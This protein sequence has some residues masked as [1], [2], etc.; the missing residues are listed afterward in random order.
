[1]TTE[2]HDCPNPRLSESHG[3]HGHDCWQCGGE[4][5][6]PEECHECALEATAEELVIAKRDRYEL[7]K[8]LTRACDLLSAAGF[9]PT[10]VSNWRHLV[11][12]TD[13]DRAIALAS[14]PQGPG[15]GNG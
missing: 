10:Q 3:D 7:R 11:T 6:N 14:Q 9:A 1:V 12:R 8:A 15:D 2:A 13:P 4:F 5:P